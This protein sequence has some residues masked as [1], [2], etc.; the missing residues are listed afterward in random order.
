MLKTD[1]EAQFFEETLSTIDENVA[2]LTKDKKDLDGKVKKLTQ[3]YLA[4]N[5]ELYNELVLSMDV[6]S[7]T[8]NELSKNSKSREKPYFGKI[9]VSFHDEKGEK[10][11]YIGKNGISDYHTREQRI[12]DWRAPISNVYYNSSL[13]ETTYAAPEGEVQVSL[14]LKR[15]F[16]IEKS[17]LNGYYDSEEITNDELL[18][19]Y[20]SKNK[21]VV[22]KDIVASIQKEQNAIIR[23]EPHVNVLVQGVAGSGKTTVAMHRISYLL[24]NYKDSLKP[25]QFVVIASNQLFLNYITAM[26]PE[27]DVHNINQS[28]MRDFLSDA[29]RMFDGSF[30]EGESAPDYMYEETADFSK[31]MLSL[32]EKKLSQVREQIFVLDEPI[33]GT[34]LL[35]ADE[36]ASYLKNFESFDFYSIA[37]IL[38]NRLVFLIKNRIEALNLENRKAAAQYRN[39]FKNRCKRYKY[40]DLWKELQAEYLQSV[41]VSRGP[42]GTSLSDLSVMLLLCKKMLPSKQTAAIRH[43]IIDEAQDFGLL[44]YRALQQTFQKARFTVVG[45]IMQNISG[46]GTEG[47]EEVRQLAFDEKASVFSLTKSYRNTIQITEFANSI[48]HRYINGD[49]L[50]QPVIR[51]GKPV[52]FSDGLPIPEKLAALASLLDDFAKS[53]Y[54]MISVICKTKADAESLIEELSGRDG[55]SLLGNESDTLQYG[56]YVG[57]VADNKGLEF[58]AVVVWDAE[59]YDLTKKIDAKLFYVAATRALH[60]LHVFGMNRPEM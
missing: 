55:V 30:A 32:L 37:E 45:D 42:K 60:E 7:M 40:K 19:K 9:N 11:L 20:L 38:D 47:W 13:G 10:T 54:Q 59:K 36:I 15:T 50:V 12:V 49:Y 4:G 16:D 2:R 28:V 34:S 14:N 29:I 6:Q 5:P 48:I 52:G 57:A 56:I 41:G 31:K 24:Y 33:L 26:L 17:V 21:D 23:M 39:Y 27:L 53:G 18:Q 35:P 44:L 22:L 8:G 3:L 58:D 25:E 1:S 51:N 46:G 43:I